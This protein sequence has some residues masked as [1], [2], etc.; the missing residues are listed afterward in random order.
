MLLDIEPEI[1]SIFRRFPLEEDL[2]LQYTINP[3]P[4]LPIVEGEKWY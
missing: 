1:Q 3:M 2:K 4:I